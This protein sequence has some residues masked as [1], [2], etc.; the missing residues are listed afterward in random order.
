[1]EHLI[2]R[3]C[4][5][6]KEIQRYKHMRSP[7]YVGFPQEDLE[8]NLETAK[9]IAALNVDGVKIHP[10]HIIKNTKMAREYLENPFKLLTL[11]EYAYRAARIIEIL[12]QTMVIHK[13]NRRS[14]TRQINS[15][16]LLYI[17]KKVRGKGK[18]RARA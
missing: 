5:K 16:R 2:C 4:F 17:F 15:P 6:N 9:L 8:D 10:L 3:C 13:I 14:R 11:E 7:L 1:M 12:P 18:D